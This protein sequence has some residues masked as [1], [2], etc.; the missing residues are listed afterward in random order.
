MNYSM[1]CDVT[2]RLVHNFLHC[3]IW[4]NIPMHLL[5]H[6]SGIGLGTS[7]FHVAHKVVVWKPQANIDDH[8]L[9]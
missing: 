9:L 7:P 3:Q 2:M 1:M 6:Q 8:R 5:R 4:S